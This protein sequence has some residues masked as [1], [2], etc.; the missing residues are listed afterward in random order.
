MKTPHVLLFAIT[1]FLLSSCTKER[2]EGNGNVITELRTLSNFSGVVNSGSKHIHITYG[3]DYRVELRGSSN[4]LPAY[5][6]EIINGDL[7][8]YYDRVNVRHDDIEV[9]VTM[10][11]IRKANLSGSGKIS[12]QGNFPAQNYFEARISGSGDIQ[13]FGGLDVDELDVNISGS[14]R[15]DLLNIHSRRAEV[16]ISGSGDAKVHATDHLKVRISGSGRTYYMG[17]P[18]IESDI[19]GSGKVVRH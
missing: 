15:A 4:L 9:Y 5:K 2:L 11:L 12:I 10:P 3:P 13:M 6:T 1:I 19:S 16:F 14:G 17:N 18:S 7:N 8:M